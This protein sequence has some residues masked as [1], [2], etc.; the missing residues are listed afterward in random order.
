VG[1]S[2]FCIDFDQ[3]IRAV[4]QDHLKVR[5]DHAG[6]AGVK[7]VT[8]D[9]R[10]FH[11]IHFMSASNIVIGQ[12]EGVHKKTRRKL[13]EFQIMFLSDDDDGGILLMGKEIREEGSFPPGQSPLRNKISCEF[14]S[15][16]CHFLRTEKTPTPGLFN[17]SFQDSL[18]CF[19]DAGPECPASAYERSKTAK[20]V[21]TI[22]NRLRIDLKI[23]ERVMKNSVLLRFFKTDHIPLPPDPNFEVPFGRIR[24]ILKILSR[25]SNGNLDQNIT[26]DLDAAR[27]Q[28]KPQPSRALVTKKLKNPRQRTVSLERPRKGTVQKTES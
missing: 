13:I 14:W 9:L 23:L 27:S 1:L 26:D 11:V 28:E 3:R 10:I 20:R 12:F 7:I 18:V 16:G 21:L 24:Y 4:R 25:F 22:F 19:V 5:M 8:A 6:S 15:R 2:F 17:Q